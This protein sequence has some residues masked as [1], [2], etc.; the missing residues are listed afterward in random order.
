M[1]VNDVTDTLEL[2]LALS[3]LGAANFDTCGTG[4]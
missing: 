1:K 2:A 3:G 4:M